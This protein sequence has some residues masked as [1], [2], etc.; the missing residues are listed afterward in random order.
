MCSIGL[1]ELSLPNGFTHL[2]MG[3][4]DLYDH[5]MLDTICLADCMRRVDGQAV[6]DSQSL[7]STLNHRDRKLLLDRLSTD[8][9]GPEFRKI[10]KACKSC[11]KQVLIE[12]TLWNF[13]PVQGG[14]R[15]EKSTQGV[16]WPWLESKWA[17]RSCAAFLV[18]WFLNNEFWHISL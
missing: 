11:H 7:V 2:R 12:I 8:N 5:W 16:P 4:A 18:L 13:F 15:D 6:E 1:V 9:P 3:E 10:F 14:R 17:K